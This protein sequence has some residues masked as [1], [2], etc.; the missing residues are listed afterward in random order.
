MLNEKMIRQFPKVELHCHLDGSIRPETLQ[1]IAR[2]QNL[3]IED[4]VAE[5][6]NKMT[7]PP[8]VKNLIDYLKCFDYVAPFL[9]TEIALSMAAFDVMEQAFLD[10]I[11]YVEIRFAPS[12]SLAKGL[13]VKQTIIAV[14]KGIA[15]AETRYPSIKGNILIC[16]MRQEGLAAIETIFNS[17]IGLKN[18]YVAGVDLA[19]PEIDNFVGELAPSF[20]AVVN[21]QHIPLTLHAGECGCVQNIIEAIKIGATRIGHGIALK[22]DE[23]AQRFVASQ[24]VCLECCPTSNVQTKA[25]THYGEFPVRMWLKNGV[26][27]C[28]NTDNRTVSGTTLTREYLHLVEEFALTEAEFRQINSYGAAFAF[29]SADKKAAIKEMQDHF[30]F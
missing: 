17:S 12:L 11:V 13:S 8:D 18:E 19:G 4:S 3:P 20:E 5:I 22:D 10:G 26:K 6:K 7:A 27:F 14:A 15:E 29:T 28:L 24:N 2:V 25:L 1:K 9:Q 21:G 23:D 16:G 30:T